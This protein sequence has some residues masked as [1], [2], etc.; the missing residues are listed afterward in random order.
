MT[1]VATTDKTEHLMVNPSNPGVA[2]LP[3]WWRQ[4]VAVTGQAVRSSLF[5]K[6][7]LVALVLVLLPVAF[8]TIIGIF[9]LDD[10]G[11]ITRNLS[12]ART[13]FGIVYSTFILGAVLFLGSALM[14]TSLLRGEMLN[15]SIHYT[16]LAPVR[17]EILVLGKFVGG[18]FSA[19]LL[20]GLATLICYL[21]I[22]LPYGINRLSMDLSGGIALD[23]ITIY[24]S[25]TF[26]ACLG[27]G[28]VFMVTGILFRN[29]LIPV[30]VVAGWEFINFL[31]P[32]ALKLIS[33]IYYLKSLMPV[34]IDEGP[35]PLAVVASPLSTPV[36]VLGIFVLASMSIAVTIYY[37]R[38]LEI[39]Y[40][41]D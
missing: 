23:Q 37:L 5:S 13:I 18:L 11:P 10:G 39:R 9:R 12:Y 28:S 34:L 15:R 1:F 25:M 19:F 32:P 29:P 17:R 33:V 40:T 6:R 4:F 26:L 38:R 27:Y 14:F 16:L 30:L 3:L 24:L 8:L 2:G 22:Y 20:F 21:L 7:V 41:D 36:A 31:L 35:L